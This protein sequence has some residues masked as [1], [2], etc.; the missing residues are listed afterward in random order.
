MIIT[1]ICK[2][3]FVGFI[4]GKG[5]TAAAGSEK[6]NFPKISF[7]SPRRTSVDNPGSRKGEGTNARATVG[8][9]DVLAGRFGKKSRFSGNNPTALHLVCGKSQRAAGNRRTPA[10]PASDTP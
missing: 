6:G 7:S 3:M 4:P 9:A 1:L 5:G 2:P 8:T 10:T